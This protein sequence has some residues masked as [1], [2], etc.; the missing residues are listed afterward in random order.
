MKNEI[1][2]KIG[3]MQDTVAG[4][5]ITISTL[6]R[7]ELDKK[8]LSEALSYASLHRMI[9]LCRLLLT[10]GA[11]PNDRTFGALE[12]TPLYWAAYQ[13]KFDLCKMLLDSGADVNAVDSDNRTPLYC[14]ANIG[15]KEI[16]RLLIERGAD[17]NIKRNCGT[18]PLHR[19][20]I[21]GYTEVCKLLIEAGADVNAKETGHGWTPLHEAA[22]KGYESIADMLI[23]AGADRDALDN[24]G[25]TPTFL[26]VI[27]DKARIADPK[28]EHDKLEAVIDKYV[29]EYKA[30]TH[31]KCIEDRKEEIQVI[32]NKVMDA[33]A[34]TMS[35]PSSVLDIIIAKLKD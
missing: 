24:D 30:G 35:N 23:E 32:L 1:L 14:A 18:T 7:H 10:F 22:S 28:E 11:D 31:C 4:E 5:M 13:G 12:G 3:E 9:D 2:K 21:F 29:A 20:V 33:L 27:N 17:P 16:C 19:A 26:A 34:I 15:H 25:H 8:K 6:I